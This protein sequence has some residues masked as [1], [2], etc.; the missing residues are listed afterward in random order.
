MSSTPVSLPTF[1]NG[2]PGSASQTVAAFQYI[3]NLGQNN[4]NT[5]TDI[6][7]NTLL[8][9]QRRVSYL[10]SKQQAA[11][12]LVNENSLVNFSVTDFSNIDQ[13]ETTA[14]VRVDTGVITCSEQDITV[15]AVI[16]SIQFTSSVGSIET[17]NTTSNMYR[18]YNTNSQ[19]PT[20]TFAITLTE[21]INLSV[22][23]FDIPSIANN[24]IINVSVSNTG[25][26]YTPC[27]SYSLIGYR[28]IIYLTP[29]PIQYISLSIT[30]GNPDNLGGTLYTFGITDFVGSSTQYRLLSD[31][32]SNPISFKP[33]S[34]NC[35][36]LGAADPGLT[37]FLSLAGE[38]YVEVNLNTPI[39]IPG[40]MTGGGTATVSSPGLL[41]VTLNSNIYLNTLV[42]IDESISAI[43]PI[44][45]GIT[46]GATNI[47]NLKRN[48]ISV[49]GNDLYYIPYVSGDSTKTFSVSYL[50]G[51]SQVT[52]QL[53]VQLFSNDNNSSPV[54]NGATLLAA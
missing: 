46:E 19:T 3:Y 32:V 43:L 28:L 14:T 41:S 44:V 40:V 38:N 8:A 4:L 34:T 13:S 22:L 27:L 6:Y 37:Y 48:Y 21:S 54:F 50:Y 25:I 35:Q 49:I 53:K 45:Y 17:L 36:V 30:P 20:G 26:T 52:A 10:N 24:P 9:F 16:K 11:L 51:P 42:V 7:T 15:E 31:F 39:A 5:L 18:V 47:A 29:A 23:V 33:T 1:S 2:Q 12:K